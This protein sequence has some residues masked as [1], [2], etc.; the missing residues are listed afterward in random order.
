MD[1]WLVAREFSALSVRSRGF[2]VP[3]KDDPGK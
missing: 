3:C 1:V 2:A